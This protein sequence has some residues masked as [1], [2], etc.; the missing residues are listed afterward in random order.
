MS[1]TAVIELTGFAEDCSEAIRSLVSLKHYLKNIV[2]IHP[3]YVNDEKSMHVGWA[4]DRVAL[5]PVP[6]TFVTRL[7]EVFVQGATVVEINPY[8][9]VRQG[10]LDTIVSASKSATPYQTHLGVST[11]LVLDRFSLFYGFLIISYVVDWFWQR[12]WNRDKMYQFLDI[13]ARRVV[14]VG[15]SKYL[16]ESSWIWYIRNTGCIPRFYGGESAV[17]K[18][19]NLHGWK[20]VVWYFYN[21]RHYRWSWWII[22]F[23][24]IWAIVSMAAYGLF[25]GNITSIYILTVWMWEI[26]ASYLICENYIKMD[27]SLL[28]YPLFPVFWLLFP[29][30]I[31]CSKIVSPQNAWTQ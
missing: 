11:S 7:D 30:V 9:S 19:V 15:G 22:P 28:L 1:L 26:T 12:V 29:L 27:Y 24:L 8:C 4:C 2:I 20:L 14:E 23:S 31:V 13:R 21:H 3:A 16:P 6:V 5:E 25:L 18:P 10:A 17:T